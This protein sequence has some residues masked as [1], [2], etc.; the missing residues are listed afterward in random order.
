MPGLVQLPRNRH[1]RIAEADPS[2]TE[3][4]PKAT[5]ATEP[6]AAPAATDARPVTAAHAT[7]HAHTA[8]ADRTS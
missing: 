1:T 2:I 6:A 8:T 7:E 5:S 4:R 3:S